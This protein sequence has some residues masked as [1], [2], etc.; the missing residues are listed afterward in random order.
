MFFERRGYKKNSK[1]HD[2]YSRPH[3]QPAS[4]KAGKSRI[5]THLHFFLQSIYNDWQRGC[6]CLDMKLKQF[7]LMKL[8]KKS[9]V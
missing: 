8:F 1:H 6:V 9:P 5:Y 7:L 3:H 4:E 2:G